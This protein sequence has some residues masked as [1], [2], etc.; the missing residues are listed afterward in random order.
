MIDP[1]RGHVGRMH[2]Q[3]IPTAK[4]TS[5]PVI[6][7]IDRGV[8]LIVAADGDETQHIIGPGLLVHRDAIK[9]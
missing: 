4:D 5:V 1:A 3:Y 8:V 9:H 7:A 6:Q 2:E